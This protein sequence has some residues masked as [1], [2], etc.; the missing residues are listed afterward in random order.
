MLF[1][2]I[3]CSAPMMHDVDSLSRQP[4]LRKRKKKGQKEKPLRFYPYLSQSA[5]FYLLTFTLAP[6]VLSSDT[7]PPAAILPPRSSCRDPPAV[8]L[9][10]ITL[11][12]LLPRSS[13]GNP[14][15][16]ILLPILLPRSSCLD[17]DIFVRQGHLLRYN[18]P[19]LI[20]SYP[21]LSCPILSYPILS[22][23]FLS[24]PFLS[25][26]IDLPSLIL[27]YPVLPYPIL[28]YPILSFPVLSNRT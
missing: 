19:S 10:P 26:S 1:S 23:P 24:L 21:V 2:N 17:S 27:S 18:L 13:C 15:A 6:S 9:L 12:T 8:I 22:F 25:Y 11:S 16:S 14:H 28:S 20:L 5:L 7:N 3:H 4:I